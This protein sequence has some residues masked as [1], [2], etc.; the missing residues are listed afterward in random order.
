MLIDKAFDSLYSNFSSQFIKVLDYLDISKR[1]NFPLKENILSSENINDIYNDIK[2][3]ENKILRDIISGNNEYKDLIQN[4]LDFF[5]EKYGDKPIQLINEI[6]NL[7]TETILKQLA[8]EY[9]KLFENSL[10]SLN[11]IIENNIKLANP[12]FNGVKITS[13]RTQAFTDK[14]NAYLS[15]FNQLNNYFQKNLKNDLTNLYMSVINLLQKFDSISI[16]NKYPNLLSFSQ[17][18]KS[19]SDTLKDR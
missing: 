9:D 2:N 1:E 7:L 4:Q 19:V 14:A 18:H 6:K 3:L 16:I 17:L 13:Y 12:Y 15:S 10:N 8:E 5:N 11:E